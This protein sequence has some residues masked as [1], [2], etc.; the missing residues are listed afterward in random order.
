MFV[1]I[2]HT[3]SVSLNKIGDL[4]YYEGDLQATRSYYFQALDVRRSAIK[5]SSTVPSQVSQLE[6][7]PFLVVIL[8]SLMTNSFEDATCI[9]RSLKV[10]ISSYSSYS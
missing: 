2:T 6:Q 9:Y 7:L 3:L 8:L 10:G 4:K 1:Q 5:N